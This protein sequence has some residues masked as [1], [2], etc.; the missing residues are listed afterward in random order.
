MSYETYR[1]I[2]L[3]GAILAGVMLVT[4]IVLFFVLK[5][6]RVIGDL[7]GATARK[8]IEGIRSQTEQSGDKE[9]K[10]SVSPAGRL[11]GRVTKKLE[12]ENARTDEKMSTQKLPAESHKHG[13]EKGKGTA[14]E[15]TLLAPETTLLA[16]E[17]TLLAPETT[18]LAPESNETTI[19]TGYEETVTPAQG[20]GAPFPAPAAGET[21]QLAPTAPAPAAAQPPQP[22]PSGGAAFVIEYEI[23]FINSSEYIA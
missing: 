16:P 10:R 23:T 18:L 9:Q 21:M 7:T 3:I 15:T 22:A 2:F 8:A 1:L 6:P 13:K 12:S 20:V 5:I 11:Q 19:L 4:A 17:T 14:P